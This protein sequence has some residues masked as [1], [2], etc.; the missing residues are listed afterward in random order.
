MFSLNSSVSSGNEQDG[1]VSICVELQSVIARNISLQL[2]TRELAGQ[3]NSA[4]P[5]D[6]NNTASVTYTFGAGP[7]EDERTLCA[8]IPLNEDGIVEDREVFEV[9]LRENPEEMD[10]AIDT[11]QGQVF[12]MDS[13]L[14]SE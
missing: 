9:L 8:L 14:D 12:I 1:E 11:D 5:S 10:V 3:N 7:L 6:Y 2:V 4:S 13:P